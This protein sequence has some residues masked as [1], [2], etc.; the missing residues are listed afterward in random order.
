MEGNK[1]VALN[2][3]VCQNEYLGEEPVGCCSG[4]DCGCLGL[5]TE[6]QVCSEECYSKLI[7]KYRNNDI[8]GLRSFESD[9]AQGNL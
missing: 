6:P 5:P 2:C 4:R 8:P 7:S 9:Y 3:E 1:L